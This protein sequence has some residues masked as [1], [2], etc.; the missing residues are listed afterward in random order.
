MEEDDQEMYRSENL[1]K[2]ENDIDGQQNPKKWQ[3]CSCGRELK[4]SYDIENMHDNKVNNISEYNLPI[5]T[6]N[7]YKCI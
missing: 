6:L 5:D 4:N 3:K 2:E 7:T 1:N